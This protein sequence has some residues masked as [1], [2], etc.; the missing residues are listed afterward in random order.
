[1]DG[2]KQVLLV[3]SHDR[4][5]CWVPDPQVAE[6]SV[7]SAH[8][9]QPSSPSAAGWEAQGLVKP[10]PRDWPQKGEA[11][12]LGHVAEPCTGQKGCATSHGGGRP[13]GEHCR[14]G[15]VLQLPNVH[16]W[17][18]AQ[19]P[20]AQERTD[21]WFSGCTGSMST[22]EQPQPCMSGKVSTDFS[23]GLQKQV[24]KRILVL[25]RFNL[26]PF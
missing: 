20:P 16:P 14:V 1:M 13:E 7:H 9:D 25:L 22:S 4:P 2:P 15:K 3:T 6:H 24:L 12:A 21:G 26:L 8:G 17:A 5:L 10:L 23:N 19:G 18:G 11:H